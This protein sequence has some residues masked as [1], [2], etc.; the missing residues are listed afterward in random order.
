LFICPIVPSRPFH[1]ATRSAK[2]TYKNHTHAPHTAAAAGTRHPLPPN[3][4]SCQAATAARPAP[5]PQPLSHGECHCH[6]HRRQCQCHRPPATATA[7]GTDTVRRVALGC[8]DPVASTHCHCHCH[9][10][11]LCHCHSHSHM[12]SATATVTAASASATAPPPLP[13]P[14][15]LTQSVVLPSAARIPLRTRSSQVSRSWH[16][17]QL[18]ATHVHSMQGSQ[19]IGPGS[20]IY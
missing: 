19:I 20:Q 16:G 3:G 2:K 7:T 18:H 15:A 14:P 17:K 11:C 12:A 5:L 13:L 1:F 10:H 4:A 9:C 6:C 8:E